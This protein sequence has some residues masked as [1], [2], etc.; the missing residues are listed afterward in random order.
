MAGT[1]R[2]K[3]KDGS[4]NVIN[5]II[6]DET[7]VKQNYSNYEMFVPVFREADPEV[8]ARA[9]RNHQ[10]RKTEEQVSR[11]PDHPQNGKWIAWRKTLRDW[12]S[13][14][15]FPETRPTQPYADIN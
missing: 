10:L 4:G 3:I 6:A 7:F 9:W 12:P 1:S 5:T 2:W 8:M 15:D 14:A 11:H 13:T